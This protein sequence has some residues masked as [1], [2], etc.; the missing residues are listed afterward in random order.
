MTPAL[1]F[2]R[3]TARNAAVLLV[4][5]A[6]VSPFVVSTVPQVVGADHSYTVLSSSMSPGIRAGDQVIV[7]DAAPR[8]IHENDVITFRPPAS[9]HFGN[10]RR[11]THRVVDVVHRNGKVYFRTKGDANDAPDP[12][13]VPGRDVVGVVWFHI[14][15]IGYAL[16]FANTPLGLFS[17]VVVPA[18]LLAASELYNLVTAVPAGEEVDGETEQ[19]A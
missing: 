17:L 6:V 11:V 19:E 7:R 14:P 5:A 2:D 16:E 15:K 3:R 13:L 18:A 4:L 9:D 10:V 8:S 1:D 12:G